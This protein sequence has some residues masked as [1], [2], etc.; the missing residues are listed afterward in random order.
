MQ[1]TSKQLVLLN[2]HRIAT[3]CTVMTII[4]TKNPLKSFYQWLKLSF[5][6]KKDGRLK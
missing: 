3:N 6:P 4:C 1:S 5:F 2:K